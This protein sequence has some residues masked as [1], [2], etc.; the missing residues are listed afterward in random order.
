MPLKILVV[1][2]EPIIGLELEYLLCNAGFTVLGPAP[3]VAAARPFV[4]EADG[5]VLDISLGRETSEDIA[6][7][8]SERGIPF[9]VL[10]ALRDGM[11]AGSWTRASS[12]WLLKPVRPAQLIAELRKFETCS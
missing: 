12:A 9:V 4:P 11:N 10:T 3:S 1:E 7:A 2:D 5:A 6:L 8:L